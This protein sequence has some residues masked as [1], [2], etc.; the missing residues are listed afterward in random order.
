MEKKNSIE[1]AILGD[2]MGDVV[3]L[4]SLY[5]KREKNNFLSS[6]VATGGG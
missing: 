3:S 6:E 2:L 5:V 1:D 4:L